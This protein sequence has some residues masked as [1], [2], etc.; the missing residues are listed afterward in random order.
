MTCGKNFY[1][2]ELTPLLTT[3]SH[4]LPLP[5][6]PLLISK[7]FSSTSSEDSST[8][9]D[10]KFRR[11]Y[12]GLRMGTLREDVLYS[13]SHSDPDYTSSSEQSC[14][15][16]IYIGANGQSL[17]DRELTD[18]EGPPRHVPRTNPRLPR[19]PSGSRSSGDDSDS[20]QSVRSMRSG[21][22]GRLPMRRL[23]SSSPTPP[24]LVKVGPQ[25][26][27]GSPKSGL[28]KMAQRMGMQ[29]SLAGSDGGSLAE[30]RP[31][32]IHCHSSQSK[33]AKAI[34]D[35]TEPMPG[36]QWIDGPGAAIYP[37]PAHS[38]MWVDGPQ[39]FVVQHQTG[40]VSKLTQ[41]T[42]SSSSSPGQQIHR[43][44]KTPTSTVTP[45][46]TPQAH[47]HHHRSESLSSRSRLAP[48][49]VNAEEH[50][51]D[52]PREMIAT[53][54]ASVQ[55]MH[56]T[57]KTTEA[58]NDPIKL[59]PHQSS[60]S[61]VSTGVNEK[62]LK[63]ALAK[64]ILD[65]K[66]RT[67]RH[68][69]VD[70]DSS[71]MVEAA[72]SRPVSFTSSEGHQCKESSTPSGGKERTS[73][74]QSKPGASSTGTKCSKLDSAHAPRLQKCQLPGSSSP[75]HRVAQ[76]IKSVASEQGGVQEISCS[77]SVSAIT[78]QPGQVCS[79][80][81]QMTPHAVSSVAMADA[82]T[83]TEHD[84]D[85]ERLAEENGVR[86]SSS[87]E[88][89]VNSPPTAAEGSLKPDVNFVRCKESKCNNILLDTSL[90]S[91]FDTS[92]MMNAE[93]VYEMEVE[94]RLDFMKAKD[95]SRLAA[96]VDNETFSSQS[97]SNR[98]PEETERDA[99]ASEI[100][101]LLVQ[102]TKALTE[103]RQTA[104]INRHLARAGKTCPGREPSPDLSDCDSSGGMGVGKPLLSRKPD[105]ASNPN[106]LKLCSEE[107]SLH[108]HQQQHFYQNPL[109]TMYV[110]TANSGNVLESTS[111]KDY[112]SCLCDNEE[113][114]RD[115]GSLEEDHGA[116]GGT[117]RL[118]A[119]DK[120]P[121]S[122]RQQP[123]TERQQ[124]QSSLSRP[125]ISTSSSRSIY[126]TAKPLYHSNPKEFVSKSP[127]SS[128]PSLCHGGG[129]VSSPRAKS[130]FSRGSEISNG[131]PC[132]SSSSGMSHSPLSSATSSPL[133]SSSTASK[134]S[135][136]SPAP[137]KSSGKGVN[138]GPPNKTPTFCSPKSSSPSAKDKTRKKDK[139]K[140]GS[141]STCPRTA[142]LSTTGTHKGKGND[143]DSGNDSGIVTNEQRL[144]SPYATV[145]KPRAQSHSSSG[146]GSDN[147]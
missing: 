85:F 68:Q 12:R 5:L 24:G 144:L 126:C 66:D 69:S 141:K 137:L 113:L 16:V 44:E 132:C 103:S 1:P 56:T 117:A 59:G 89:P 11:P 102:H 22:S 48:K 110:T 19:R 14:D 83:N 120:P 133:V 29:S 147:R 136:C 99:Q 20:G 127:A 80:P 92:M 67:D 112:D 94:E 91:S 101:S 123:S 134:S 96:D 142:H 88:S 105:G 108:Q 81:A 4:L 39:A 52:G 63:Q 129:K 21:D 78:K 146:H 143:S 55:P 34:H 27:P 49:K 125:S 46:S 43:A 57:C 7:Q 95:G 98:D 87:D 71:L 100:E 118:A 13:S 54:S 2:L 47:H 131:S 124:Q 45:L 115:K 31:T 74:E 128:S 122:G 93:C 51:V 73:E 23:M 75:T 109:E 61:M 30:G 40:A 116:G 106:L 121:L 15:T 84:S 97:C 130:K 9:G 64:H 60:K 140:D 8:D 90:D 50:W 76:W 82:E 28:V 145:T 104:Q 107:G 119:K 3:H 33:L 6:P 58:A 42:S 26:M 36:E 79:T 18:N 86:S 138:P 62:A 35:K 37:E 114:F 70:S 72:E 65:T 32:K 139:D 41:P 53:D 17:S 38:E 111:S 25:S 77:S 135:S 10:A